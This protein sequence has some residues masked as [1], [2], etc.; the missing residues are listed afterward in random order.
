V[1]NLR[2]ILLVEDRLSWRGIIQELLEDV[3]FAVE[4]AADYPSALP[5]IEAAS[6]ALAILDI[7]LVRG[8]RNNRDGLHLAEILSRQS[9]PP[10]VLLM[11]GTVGLDSELHVP[12]NVVGY[13]DKTNF[14]RQRFL[15]KVGQATSREPEIRQWLS[16][17]V[18]TSQPDPPE[19][20]RSQPRGSQQAGGQVLVVEDSSN[21]QEI[22]AELVEDTG[23]TAEVASSYGEALGKLRR[24]AFHLVVIDLKLV[25]ESNRPASQIDEEDLF[26]GLQLV[27]RIPDVPIIVVSEYTTPRIVNPIADSSRDI[28]FFAKSEFKREEFKKLV[29]G[30]VSERIKCAS[31]DR[32]KA[33]EGVL[34]NLHNRDALRVRARPLLPCLRFSRREQSDEEQ[35]RELEEMVEEALARYRKAAVA[36]EKR[37]WRHTRRVSVDELA[38]LIQ[39]IL[40]IRREDREL[41]A[42]PLSNAM[43]RYM[44]IER[45]YVRGDRR[46][47][48]AHDYGFSLRALNDR[49]KEAI[50]ELCKLLPWR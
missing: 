14:H 20:V 27:Q 18:Q 13:V 1:T 45:Q 36:E 22:L 35:F 50:L 43:L 7:C 37:H 10:P 5:K 29:A 16:A 21:W 17:M 49:R 46:E 28:H 4:T 34:R 33:I 39:D 23:L 11:S 30:L 15:M 9:P 19:A 47:D 44:V 3:G 2:S 24:H 25:D 12:Q 31:L 6:F 40:E 48:I 32:V 38:S 41:K 26:A 42:Q 8:D